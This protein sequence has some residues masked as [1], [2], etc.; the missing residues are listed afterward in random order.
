MLNA[1]TPIAMNTGDVATYEGKVFAN[2]GPGLAIMTAPVD[3]SVYQLERS[4]SLAVDSVATSNLNAHIVTFFASGLPGVLLVL[5]LY[6]HFR[7]A[8]ATLRRGVCAWLLDLVREL[9]CFPT[10]VR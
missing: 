8:G 10:P 9:C 3:W 5:V 7:R 4:L 1:G 2:K 6:L